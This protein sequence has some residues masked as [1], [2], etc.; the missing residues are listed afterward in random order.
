MTALLAVLALHPLVA[1][2]PVRQDAKATTPPAFVLDAPTKAQ[3]LDALI[4]YMNE[5][6]IVPETAKKIEADL[7]AWMSGSDY[8]ILTDPAAFALKV[9]ELMKRDVTDAHLR[10]RYSP[11][12]LPERKEATRPSQ[13]ELKRYADETRYENALFEHVERLKGNVG[14]IEFRG[15]A[16]PDDMKRPLEGA[17]TFLA[18]VDAF[19][20][21]LRQNGGGDP[22]GVQLF[23]SYFFDGKPVHINNI[24]FRNGDKIDKQEFWTLKKVDG[25]RFPKVPLYVLT[26]KRTGSGAEECAYDL[27]QTH[28]G[29]IIGTSTWG[30]A[31]PGDVVR[32]GDH[33]A[34]FIPVG[35][36]E[37]PYTKTNWE[38]IGVQPDLKVDAD[39]ALGEAH[40]LALRKL[41]ENCADEERKTE[42]QQVLDEVMK[43]Q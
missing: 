41:I 34:C 17:M 28:R 32:L 13:D 14:Y 36:A 38:G 23:C 18:N 11:T 27:Q 43:G 31:N 10:F 3:T 25:P 29:M 7:R 39:K 37:N 42:L 35:R 1:L 15:F 9:N 40:G 21:D 4:K 5:R 16:S 12:V 24:Y 30:G 22:A 2:A 19:I 20:V 6:Y 33:F 26:S 8:A